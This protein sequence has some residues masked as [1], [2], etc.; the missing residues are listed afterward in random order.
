MTHLVKLEVESFAYENAATWNSFCYRT[1]TNQ[2]DPRRKETIPGPGP[3]Q[4]RLE[5]E[6][7]WP[8]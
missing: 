8:Q 3:R 2:G 4:S 5:A 1:S 7:I 6:E